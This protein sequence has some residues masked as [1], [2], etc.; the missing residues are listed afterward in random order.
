MTT[1][2]EHFEIVR[3]KPEHVRKQIAIGTAATITVL[4]ALVWVSSSIMTGSFGLKGIGFA[5]VGA[6]GAQT[7]SAGNGSSGLVGAAAAAFGSTGGGP[8]HIEIID[9]GKSS[10]VNANKQQPEATILPF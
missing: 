10:T 6:A 3:Q 2:T 7:A 8:A 4:I 9:T 1:L 5:G